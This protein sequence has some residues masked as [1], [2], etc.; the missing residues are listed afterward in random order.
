VNWEWK[1][2]GNEEERIKNLSPSPRFGHTAVISNNKL[3]VFGGAG[4]YIPRIKKRETFNDT[5]IFDIGKNKK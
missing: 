3:V 4:S 2:L 1:T 5:Y